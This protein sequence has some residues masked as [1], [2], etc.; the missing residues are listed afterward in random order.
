[1]PHSLLYKGAR[2]FVSVRV[3]ALS[4]CSRS[5]QSA[6][7]VGFTQGEEGD[8]GSDEDRRECSEDNTKAHGEGETL[9]AFATQEQDTEQ[10]D[11]RWERGVDG[12]SQRLVDT[13]VE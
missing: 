12:S 6:S 11:K 4:L 7:L 2:H 8:G 3:V 13:V 9:D 10:H 5:F 1:M